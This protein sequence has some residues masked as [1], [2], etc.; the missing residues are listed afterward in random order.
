MRKITGFVIGII[1][2]LGLT[3]CA[4]PMQTPTTTPGERSDTPPT[5]IQFAGPIATADERR[6]CQSVGGKVVRAGL[7]GFENCA[8]PYSDAG[9]PCSDSADCDGDCRYT[10]E[11][12]VATP[13]AGV[14]QADTLPFG[15]YA[16]VEAGSP[17]AMLCVD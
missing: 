13:V 14:C 11:W 5:T 16:R 4:T 2:G 12:P 3:A 15:C 9:Q 1:S 6:V 17:T 7:A 10:G 8:I